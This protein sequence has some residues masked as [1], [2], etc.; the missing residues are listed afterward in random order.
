MATFDDDL[1]EPVE[2]SEMEPITIFS[3]HIL[4]SGV[5]DVL[6]DSPSANDFEIDG[7]DTD[8]TTI[9]VAVQQDGEDEPWSL[10]FRHD[11]AYYSGRDWPGRLMGM[12]QY[13]EQFP[14]VPRKSA[15][16]KCIEGF[17]FALAT[18]WE[19]DMDTESDARIPY[20]FNV[21]LRLDAVLFT[22]SLLIDARGRTLISLDGDFDED[23]ELPK[24]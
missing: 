12:R 4:P 11:P 10:T 17:R 15:I 1:L 24:S 23:A 22:P 18:I 14:D 19:P 6:R 16:L 5:L 13:F 9:R 3:R 7:G 21:A 20:L 2:E 8:W